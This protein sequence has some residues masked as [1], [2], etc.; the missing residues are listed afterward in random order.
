MEQG[1]EEWQWSLTGSKPGNMGVDA[2]R[3]KKMAM[4]TD[5][6]QVK[7]HIGGH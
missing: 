7:E 6:L 2:G 3:R 5:R 4:A 1:T